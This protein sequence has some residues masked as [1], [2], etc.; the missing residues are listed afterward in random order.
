[1]FNDTFPAPKTQQNT[2]REP[3][4]RSRFIS[5]AFLC[6][7][8]RRRCMS[9]LFFLFIPHASLTYPSSHSCLSLISALVVQGMLQKQPYFCICLPL[10]CPWHAGNPALSPP[11]SLLAGASGTFFYTLGFPLYL[12]EF[13]LAGHQAL[14]AGTKMSATNIK[15]RASLS[16]LRPHNW[17]TAGTA[18][19]AF[20]PPIGRDARRVRVSARWQKG[21]GGGARYRIHRLRPWRV[22]RLENAR[23][24]YILLIPSCLV[25]WVVWL[26]ECTGIG[27]AAYWNVS[28]VDCLPLGR[29][30][31]HKEE[32]PLSLPARLSPLLPYPFTPPFPACFFIS[33]AVFGHLSNAPWDSFRHEN[34]SLC[35]CF[36]LLF[37]FR[38]KSVSG[39]A[40]SGYLLQR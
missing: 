12:S 9:L 35:G 13:T 26:L 28:E 31:R 14:C 6:Y 18:R 11:K 39:R 2:C 34:S 23:G 37:G 3:Q 17:P 5:Y 30:P 32:W 10:D 29:R 38:F 7:L 25:W 19:T 16:R 27:S 33:L 40:R 8:S 4:A 1:M 20:Q 36:L 15:R 21:V 24:W 22:S